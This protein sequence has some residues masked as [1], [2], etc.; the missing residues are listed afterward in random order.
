MLYDLMKGT[1][2]TPQFAEFASAGF[3]H[4]FRLPR[5]PRRGIVLLGEQEG[6][7]KQL[8][9]RDCTAAERL[10]SAAAQARIDFPWHS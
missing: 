6:L 8:E 9:C 10:S 1:V 2:A 3:S 4:E 5:W 7:C